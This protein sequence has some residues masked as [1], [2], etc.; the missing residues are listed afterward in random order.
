MLKPKAEFPIKEARMLW[1]EG[2]CWNALG[3]KYGY[4][5]QTIKKWVGI[6]STEKEY[7][8]AHKQHCKNHYPYCEFCYGESE[9][10]QMIKNQRK[11]F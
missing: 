2:Y 3:K 10:A 6:E 1:A 8:K 9:K 4:T 11:L 5:G 7:N